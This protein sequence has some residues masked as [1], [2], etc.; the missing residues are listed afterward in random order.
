M[1]NIRPLSFLSSFIAAWRDY[2][3]EV[4]TLFAGRYLVHEMIGEGSYGMTYRCTDQNSGCIV[5]VKQARPSKDGDARL[6]L[7]REA[8]IL[9]SLN[10]PQIPAF[11]DLFT[12]KRHIYLVMSYLSGDTLEDLIFEQG[13]TYNEHACVLITLQLLELVIYIHEK[14]LVHLDLRIPNVLFKNNDINLIDFG[15]ARKIGEPPPRMKS[16]RKWLRKHSDFSS[17]DH[18]IAEEQADLQDIGHF[19]LFMLYSA[20][21]PDHNQNDSVERSWREELQLSQELK[22]VIERL[23]GLSKP[24]TGSSQFMSDLKKLAYP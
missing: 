2:P 24:Y 13:H 4:N 11:K 22:E 1:S 14:D 17:G 21:E 5:A 9:K 19:M 7:S 3:A 8:D 16:R 6:L 18:K 23:L 12:E 10:H 15:L 20:Y